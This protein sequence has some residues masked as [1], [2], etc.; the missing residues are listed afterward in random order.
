MKTSGFI[1]TKSI[2]FSLLLDRVGKRDIKTNKNPLT[3]SRVSYWKFAGPGKFAQYVDTI[4]K[5]IEISTSVSPKMF[6]LSRLAHFPHVPYSELYYYSELSPVLFVS[7]YPAYI[8]TKPARIIHGLRY[9]QRALIVYLKTT[10][11]ILC[12]DYFGS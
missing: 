3:G 2:I 7:V 11:P 6:D 5:L 9:S 4:T 12:R 10:R 8:M 1:S